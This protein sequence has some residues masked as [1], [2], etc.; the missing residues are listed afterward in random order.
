MSTEEGWMWMYMF[1]VVAFQPAH[2]A[3]CSFYQMKLCKIFLQFNFIKVKYLLFFRWNCF[4]KNSVV[5]G[6]KNA[7]FIIFEAMTN[8]N[9]IVHIINVWIKMNLV[10]SHRLRTP[11][12]EIAFTT[13]PGRKSTP[14]PKFLGTDKAYFVCHNSPNFQ[15]SLI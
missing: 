1:L 11:G 6:Q 13:L 14:T 12:E 9:S 8:I 4:Q 15:I 7:N 3:H 5:F 10:L 2:S